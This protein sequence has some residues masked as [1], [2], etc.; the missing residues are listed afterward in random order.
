MPMVEGAAADLPGVRCTGP[1]PCNGGV[2]GWRRFQQCGAS[3]HH[4]CDGE[5]AGGT[6][7]SCACCCAIL[8]PVRLSK[9]GG[10]LA[11]CCSWLAKIWIYQKDVVLS[12]TAAIEHKCNGTEA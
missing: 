4:V 1:G 8:P 3:E 12:Y 2:P 9:D 5:M 10:I 11:S 7:P 6:R